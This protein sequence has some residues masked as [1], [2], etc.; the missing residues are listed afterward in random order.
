MDYLKEGWIKIMTFK[1]T[2]LVFACLMISGCFNT[3][4]DEFYTK[5]YQKEFCRTAE[6]QRNCKKTYLL[7]E[8][9]KEKSNREEVAACLKPYAENNVTYI[10]LA[11]GLLYSFDDLPNTEPDYEKAV[12]WLTKAAESGNAHSQAMLAD[13]LGRDEYKQY[14]FYS[15]DKRFYWYKKSAENG[16][17]FGQRSMGE[18]YFHGFEGE[19]VTLKKDIKEAIKWFEKAAAQEDIPSYQMLI[20]IYSKGEADVP[21]NADRVRKYVKELERLKKKS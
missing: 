19:T 16:E 15:K 1:R 10:Q 21:V 8:S 9:C 7:V 20:H 4:K 12:Y 5:T 3:N 18:F 2:T 13:F 6:E 17:L 11:L 14:P